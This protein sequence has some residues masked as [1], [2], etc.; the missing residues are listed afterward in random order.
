[1]WKAAD[2]GHKGHTGAH[3]MKE[4]VSQGEDRDGSLGDTERKTMVGSG[5]SYSPSKPRRSNLRTAFPPLGQARGRQERSILRPPRSPG[6][7]RFGAALRPQ[8]RPTDAAS[9]SIKACESKR[10]WR[11]SACRV[12][13]Q[14]V[15]WTSVTG[16]APQELSSLD[17]VTAGSGGST[18]REAIPAGRR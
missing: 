5:E 9:G 2:G 18:R 17:L 7:A 4:K 3:S 15:R 1:M 14:P 8:L 16:G 10:L 11:G 12:R 13:G 6:Q